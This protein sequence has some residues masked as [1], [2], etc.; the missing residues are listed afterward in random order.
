MKMEQAMERVRKSAIIR[1]RGFLCII[2]LLVIAGFLTGCADVTVNLHRHLFRPEVPNSVASF[3]K[4]KQID[5]NKVINMDKKTQSWTYYNP[6]KT[7]AYKASVSLEYY[8]MDCFRDAF[9]STGMSVLYESPEPNIPDMV[10][11]IDYWTDIEFKFSVIVKKNDVTMYKQ[12][13]SVTMP[14]ANKYDTAQMEK[15]AYIM[16]NKAV[17]AVMSDQKFQGIFK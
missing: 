1:A 15:N 2:S 6:D 10:L 16:M 8:V 7:V 13:Y 9:W 14:P 11:I 4:G 12:Q 5:L 3:Y 17:L